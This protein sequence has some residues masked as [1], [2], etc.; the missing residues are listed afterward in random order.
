MKKFLL[1]FSLFVFHFSVIE[2]QDTLAHK[3]ASKSN[4]KQFDYNPISIDIGMG[5]SLITW[6]L[7]GFSILYNAG[8]EIKT[9]TPVYN[10]SLDYTIQQG[11]S[12]GFEGAYQSITDL[13]SMGG[14]QDYA[15]WELEQLTRYNISGFFLFHFSK[16]QKDDTYIG[17]KGGISI[18][19]DQILS[20]TL[21]TFPPST[22]IT[23]FHSSYANNG[24][25]QVLVGWRH[26]FSYNFGFHVQA[27]IGT[28]FLL[29]G[30][31]SYRFKTHR[32][33]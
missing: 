5:N 3:P 29:E 25:F 24:S 20:D 10:C 32:T 30:G 7:P 9:K 4:N 31:F 28:P 13:P 6:S 12:F 2:A 19:K 18:W 14:R 27:G 23:T 26:F 16:N 17:F 15:F 1:I 11:L 21:H 8:P 22:P 33:K